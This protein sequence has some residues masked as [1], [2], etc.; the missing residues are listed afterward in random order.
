MDLHPIFRKYLDAKAKYLTSLNTLTGILGKHLTSKKIDEIAKI[1]LT[2]KP[3]PKAKVERPLEVKTK[4]DLPK[5]YAGTLRG[6]VEEALAKRTFSEKDTAYLKA[7]LTMD[8]DG[9]SHKM[10]R[11]SIDV[12]RI[13]GLPAPKK[14]GPP[15]GFKSKSKVEPKTVKEFILAHPKMPAAELVALGKKHGVKFVQNTVYWYRGRNG[16]KSR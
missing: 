7:F 15:P 12:C 3:G 14:P 1:A 10:K 5:K 2:G 6:K 13:L 16:K 8:E 4:K 9:R 11:A